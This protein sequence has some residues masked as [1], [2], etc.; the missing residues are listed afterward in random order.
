MNSDTGEVRMKDKRKA[1]LEKHFDILIEDIKV[2]ILTYKVS[3]RSRKDILTLKTMIKSEVIPRLVGKTVRVSI[4][5]DGAA[6]HVVGKC[7]VYAHF[8]PLY[9]IE[10]EVLQSE[11]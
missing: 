2:P 6:I 5:S 7:F 1:K 11:H 3:R 8:S 4:P 10:F 9:E